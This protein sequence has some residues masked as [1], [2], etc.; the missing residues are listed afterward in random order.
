MYLF[1]LFL[2]ASCSA[3]VNCI[4][5]HFDDSVFKKIG[6]SFWLPHLTMGWNAVTVFSFGK[7]IFLLL[8]IV[9]SQFHFFQ[10]SFH[11]IGWLWQ[12]LL[13]FGVYTLTIIVLLEFVLTTKKQNI[14]ESI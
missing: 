1:L 7:L 10:I 14:H 8:A 9:L 11:K 3:V 2:A 5:G 6:K 12:V 4:T 13:S